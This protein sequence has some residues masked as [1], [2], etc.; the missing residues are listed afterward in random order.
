MATLASDSLE[1][2]IRGITPGSSTK[3]AFLRGP[4]AAPFQQQLVEV[5]P[6]WTSLYPTGKAYVGPD[7]PAVP[8]A[9]M[10]WVDTS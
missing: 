6:A 5:G 2:Y 3:S 1:A 10:W 8:V 9:G 4:R 7:E